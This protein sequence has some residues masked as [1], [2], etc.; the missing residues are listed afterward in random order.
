VSQPD[1]QN[2]SARAVAATPAL[3]A[4]PPVPAHTPPVCTV[5]L[6]SRPGDPWPLLLAANRDEMLA[7]PWSP[8]AAHWPGQP[9]V[10]GG[11]DDLAG[12]TWLAVNAEGV[13]AGVLNRTGSLGPAAG[14]RSRGELPLL[15]LRHGTASQAAAALAALDAGAWRPFNLVLA[16]A[17]GAFLL[18]GLGHGRAA[19]RALTA[20]LHMV[21]GTA[22]DDPHHPRIARHLP[23]F[24]ACPAPVPPD[25]GDWPALLADA[26]GPL[27]AALNVPP[28]SGF[29]T[30]SSALLA[31]PDPGRRDTAARAFLFAAAAPGQA[32]YM[33]IAW[34]AAPA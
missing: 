29:G 17:A 32:P 19:V 4:P 7:R 9:G 15:A 31:L 24:G 5:I 18:Q 12:G 22:P 27:A 16:D 28:T 34:P 3:L 8:P 23:R 20:G 13:V 11:L 2:L 33:P 14:R 25:W 10:V 30:A 21:A 26:T 1:C 6:L